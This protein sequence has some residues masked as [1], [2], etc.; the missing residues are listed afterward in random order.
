MQIFRRPS[1]ALVVSTLALAVAFTGSASAHTVASIAH[2]ISGSELKEHSVSGNRLKNNTLTGKQIKKNT[3]TGTQIK[4]STLGTVPKATAAI[5]AGTLDGIPATGFVRPI[6]TRVTKALS[7]SGQFQIVALPGLG[8]VDA[9]CGTSPGLIVTNTTAQTQDINV[10][11]TDE[12]SGPDGSYTYDFHGPMTA[13]QSTTHG[14]SGPFS[15]QL[16]GLTQ[17]SAPEM[18]ELTVDALDTGGNCIF[19]ATGESTL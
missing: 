12:S 3:L 15:L 8:E 5:V 6:E 1:P 16:E 18:V 13:G 4:E 10:A 2:K 7:T 17:G 9:T 14:V 19:N 11:F